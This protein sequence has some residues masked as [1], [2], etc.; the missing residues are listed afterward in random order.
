MNLVDAQQARRVLDRMVGIQHQSAS[1]GKS[2]KRLKCRSCAVCSTSHYLQTVKKKSMHL[3]RKNTGLWMHSLKVK[4]ERKPLIAKF[5]GT[6]NEKM[7]IHSKEE[8]N[9]ILKELEDADLSSE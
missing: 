6:E 1:V 2:K 4:G 8:V 9:K 7:T 5:Y 3:F